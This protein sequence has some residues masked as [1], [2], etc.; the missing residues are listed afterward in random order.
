[1]RSVPAIGSI[2]FHKKD[3]T[4]TAVK[5]IARPFSKRGGGRGPLVQFKPI[6]NGAIHQK[7]TRE[8]FLQNYNPQNP[9][10]GWAE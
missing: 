6:G 1:M 8:S 2:W 5:V 3:K 7:V 10:K 4:K 9:P